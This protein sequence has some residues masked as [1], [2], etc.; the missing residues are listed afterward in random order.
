M[1]TYTDEQLLAL[2][3]EQ[4]QGL[5]PKDRQFRELLINEQNSPVI[6]VQTPAY[7]DSI[8]SKPDNEDIVFISEKH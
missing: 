1:T 6:S 2:T 8:V 7:K 3:E 4:A 5:S